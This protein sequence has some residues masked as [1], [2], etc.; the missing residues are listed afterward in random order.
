MHGQHLVAA[1]PT[2]CPTGRPL[3]IPKSI[4][5]IF[6]T[7]I[8]LKTLMWHLNYKDYIIGNMC[9][10]FQV[11]W[12]STSSKTTSTKNFN[13]NGTD[14]RTDGRTDGRMDRRIEVQTRKYNAHKWGIKSDFWK[15]LTRQW[16]SLKNQNC[17]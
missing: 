7:K 3:Y 1:R 8:R 2:C 12:T 11:G 4:T 9:T 13:L 16:F 14:R 15:L 10:K 17:D 5:D 6:V